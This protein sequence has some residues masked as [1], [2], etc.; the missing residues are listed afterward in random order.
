MSAPSVSAENHPVAARSRGF[1]I[2]SILL[3]LIGWFASFELLTEYL[4]T[5]QEPDYIPNCAVS[6][7][8]TC[9]PNM[10]SWQG[11]VLG[12][13]NTIIGVSAFVAPIAVGVA[14]LAGARFAPWFWGVYQIGLLGGFVLVSWLQ[15]Q[16]IF[17]IFTLCPWCM[18]IWAVMIPLWWN[19][20]VRP[21]AV[22]DIPIG[23]RGRRFAQ[24]A[25]GWVW[26]IVVVNY[27]VI[28]AVAQFQLD[29]LA[30]FS[31]I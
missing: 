21:F 3:G 8:V 18:V 28:A 22:G 6:L 29:W 20:L 13:S 30:E 19:G 12:F 27:L 4:K 17:E 24:A 25:H 23:E 7:L 15:Y 5:L 26:V 9:G 11:S 14:T 31:R 2:F 10:G 16:S 1:A